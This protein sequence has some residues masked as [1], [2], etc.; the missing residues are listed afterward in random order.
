VE[1][2]LFS[3][4]A[5]RSWKSSRL[6]EVMFITSENASF[7]IPVFMSRS[8]SCNSGAVVSRVMSEVKETVPRFAFS[9]T[10][11]IDPA[12]RVNVVFPLDQMFDLSFRIS[13]SL[14]LRLIVTFVPLGEVVLPFEAMVSASEPVGS[15]NVIFVTFNDE[16]KTVSSNTSVTFPVFRFSANDDSVGC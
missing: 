9:D 6:S 2:V 15:D 11:T 7:R 5:P 8:N 14:S 3:A 16:D 1:F 13:R 4:A 12:P 10:S